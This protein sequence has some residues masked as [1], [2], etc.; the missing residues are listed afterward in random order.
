MTSLLYPFMT[1]AIFESYDNRKKTQEKVD[2]YYNLYF[3]FKKRKDIRRSAKSRLMKDA[4][5]NWQ[6]WKGIQDWEKE[7]FGGL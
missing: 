4:E 6:L 5:K 3:S 1:E 2:Y 7:I